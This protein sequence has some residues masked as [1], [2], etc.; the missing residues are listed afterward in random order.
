M[1]HHTHRCT[2][3]TCLKTCW[4]QPCALLHS[5][6]V[7]CPPLP[8]G[9]CGRIAVVVLQ[10]LVRLPGIR[11]QPRQQQQ[12]EGGQHRGE[13]G[14]DPEVLE[15]CALVLGP[16]GLAVQQL[17]HQRTTVRCDGVPKVVAAGKERVHRGLHTFG[18]ELRKDD[19]PGHPHPLRDDA[20]KDTGAEH[21]AM[22]R[23]AEAHVEASEQ[24][25]VGDAEEAEG[26]IGHQQQPPVGPAAREALVCTDANKR[27]DGAGDAENRC[28]ELH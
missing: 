22:V 17:Q 20:G 12:R 27:A 24:D 16:G 3:Q 13:Y 1:P 18:T 11:D 6:Q 8:Q 9:T 21:K 14:A 23:Q 5:R 4:A 7:G 15:L 2:R 10:Q 28:E 19:D 25:D 26:N